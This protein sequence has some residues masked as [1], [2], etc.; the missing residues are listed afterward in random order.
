[1]TTTNE[2]IKQNEETTNEPEMTMDELIAQQESLSEHLNKREI[3]EVTVVQITGD[4]ILVDT[5]AKK[6]GRHRRKRI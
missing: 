4:Y 5:G 1:M 3:V 6:E 2:E